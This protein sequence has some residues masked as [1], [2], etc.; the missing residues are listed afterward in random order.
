MRGKA[1]GWPPLHGAELIPRF[2]RLDLAATP[3]HAHDDRGLD[4]MNTGHEHI[5]VAA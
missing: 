4:E 1:N 3:S 2:L 5:D